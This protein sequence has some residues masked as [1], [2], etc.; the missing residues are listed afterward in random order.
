MRQ[1]LGKRETARAQAAETHH[2]LP[3]P[4]TREVREGDWEG[5]P[6][7]PEA[8]RTGARDD[9]TGV[10]RQDGHQR[11]QLRAKVR[12]VD[13]QDAASPSW[14]NQVDAIAN[15]RD[16]ARGTL[17]FTSPEGKE[18]KLREDVPLAVVV[19]RPR[20]WHLPEYTHHGQ[21][22]D[23][24]GSSTDFGLHFFHTAKQL[25]RTARARTTAAQDGSLP[26]GAAVERR[27]HVR[28]GTWASSTAPSAPPC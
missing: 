27:V 13:S 12:L 9:R 26:G 24:L 20:G 16:A 4:E 14:A 6:P 11:P 15:L 19:T 23:R 25:I 28:G 7:A 5:W 2:G 18:Y 10:A 8:C 22:R 17:G 3:S 1:L 21:R